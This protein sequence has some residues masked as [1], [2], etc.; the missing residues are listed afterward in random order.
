[1]IYRRV[2]CKVT[3]FGENI[4]RSEGY[5]P[6]TLLLTPMPSPIVDHRKPTH[7][8]TYYKYRERQDKGRGVGVV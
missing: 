8:R 5:I 7:V 2:V 3:F 6:T 1:M 4:P